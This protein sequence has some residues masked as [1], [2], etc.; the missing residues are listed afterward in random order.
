M[1]LGQIIDQI[2]EVAEIA[3]ESIELPDDKRVTATQRLQAGGETWT[4]LFLS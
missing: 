1:P 3:A 4:V 2:D